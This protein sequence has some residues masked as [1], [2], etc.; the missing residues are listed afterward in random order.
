MIAEAGQLQ[1]PQWVA[2]VFSLIGGQAVLLG[3][4]HFGVKMFQRWFMSDVINP[5]LKPMQEDL[6]V[7]KIDY[8]ATR[9]LVATHDAVLG[10]H[11]KHIAMLQ[12]K[13]FGGIPVVGKVAVVDEGEPSNG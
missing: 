3:V 6:R 9:T 4:V 5:H 13:V 1:I 7:I 10:E 12:G 2:I 8:A 11:D